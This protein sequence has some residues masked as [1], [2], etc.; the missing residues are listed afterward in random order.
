[1][2]FIRKHKFV[3]LISA[4]SIIAIF[5][6]VFIMINSLSQEDNNKYERRIQGIENVEITDSKID[7]IKAKVLEDTS[8]NKITFRLDGKLIKFFIELKKDTDE[9]IIDNILDIILDSFTEKEK[10]FYDFQV[11][12]TCEEKQKPYPIIAY[13]HRNNELFT[14]T[15]KEGSNDEE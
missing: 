7:N 3:I 6:S 8:V 5:I 9:I 1:M 10:K 4:I 14:I 12:V 11:F 2:T 13:K 15:K